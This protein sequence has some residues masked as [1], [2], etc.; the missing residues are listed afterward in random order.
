MTPQEAL[1]DTLVR[2]VCYRAYGHTRD[3]N[4][5]YLQGK[6]FCGYHNENDNET[7]MTPREKAEV[8]RLERINNID[9]MTD[10]DSGNVGGYIS[11]RANRVVGKT[12]RIAGLQHRFSPNRGLPF[13][14]LVAM[15][16][17]DPSWDPKNAVEHWISMCR[18]C[19]HTKNAWTHEP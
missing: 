1:Y 13:D 15:G 11:T 6:C 17:Y 10:Y 14:E 5:K 9:S 3:P 18:H 16:M 7:K 4:N 2:E 19:G 8:T 12:S